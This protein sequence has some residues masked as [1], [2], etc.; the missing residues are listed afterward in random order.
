MTVAAAARYTWDG[1]PGG[2]VC[3]SVD[4]LPTERVDD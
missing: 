3:L 1:G 4:V 2:I